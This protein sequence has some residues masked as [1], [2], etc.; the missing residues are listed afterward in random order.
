MEPQIAQL[1]L[2]DQQHPHL[3]KW[4]KTKRRW[5]KEI[6]YVPKNADI[7]ASYDTLTRS[8]S[9]PKSRAF[10]DSLRI[11]KMRSLSGVVPI[12]IMMAPYPCPGRCTFCLQEDGYPKSYMSDEPSAMR[13]KA[14]DFDPAAQL[15]SR[16]QQ[17]QLNGHAPEKLQIIVLGG[18]FSSYPNEY[19]KSFL[20]GIFD[21][22]N[23]SISETIEEAH[24]INENAPHKIVGMSIE[25]R[26]DWITPDEIQ[27]LRNYGVTKVQLGVQALDE[28]IYK[29]I[30]RNHSLDDVRG[31]TK[32]LR[33]AGFKINYHFMPNLPGS[34]PDKDIE[35]C[36]FMFEDPGFKPDTLKLYPCIT[37]P[38]TP[39]HQQW[40]RGEYESYD[41]D[42]LARVLAECKRLVPEYCRIDRVVRDISRNFT[43]SGTKKTNFR[44]LLE[45]YL[46]DNNIQC[47]CIRCREVFDEFSLE[48]PRLQVHGY[49]TE[50]GQERFISMESSSKIF[51]MVRLRLSNLDFNA[52]IFPE[53]HGA[54]LIRE[55]QVFGTQTHTYSKHPRAT[56]HRGLGKFLLDEAESQAKQAGYKKIAVISGVGV[57]GYYRKLGYELVETYMVKSLGRALRPIRSIIR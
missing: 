34:S 28:G 9:L 51:G 11:K 46:V 38:K 29:R 14:L 18:T 32:L 12:S 17:L 36:G 50:G 30:R 23:G 33:S 20:K 52:N 15:T 47:R 40:L 16:I 21:G 27:L 13:A 24:I 25:T 3:L 31:A 53:I 49:D 45:T 55:L 42:V 19:K 35:M 10:E 43:A 44:Q 41:D 8:G 1:I 54:A 26:P 57:R 6:G 5:A 4:E 39:L 48:T 7:R 37:I 2:K 22:A 56:Q